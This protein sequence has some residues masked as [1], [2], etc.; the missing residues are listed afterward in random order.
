MYERYFNLRELPFNVTPDPR[1]FYTNP[2]SREALATLCYGIEYRKG[3]ILVTGEAGTGKTTLLKLFMQNAA[4]QV[5]AALILDP[6]LSFVELLHCA[7]DGFGLAQMGENRF[8][9]IERFT[10]YLLEQRNYHHRVALLLDEAQELAD[11]LLEELRLL[12]DLEHGGDKLLQL[13]LIGQPELESRLDQEKFRQL[14]QRI[15]LRSHV[16]PL[17]AE[18]IGPYVGFRLRAAGYSG[19]SIFRAAALQRIGYFSKGIPRLINVI[20]DNALLIACA[21]TQHAI[22]TEIIDEIAEDLRLGGHGAAPLPS[23]P[24]TPVGKSVVEAANSGKT[25]E[26][27]NGSSAS[28]ELQSGVWSRCVKAFM[29]LDRLAGPRV[30]RFFQRW[31]L[32]ISA[33]TVTAIVVSLGG[34]Y[35]TQ[36]DSQPLHSSAIGKQQSQPARTY[37]NLIEGRLWE[38]SFKEHTQPAAIYE[39]PEQRDTPASLE[40]KP[41][42]GDRS[43]SAK[44]P[45][46]ARRF[47]GGQ[48]LALVEPQKTEAGRAQSSVPGYTVVEN[49]YVRDKPT[50]KAEV[51]ATL[52]PGTRIQVVGRFGDYFEV[53]SSDHEAIRGYV[54]KEDAFFRPAP[55]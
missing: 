38:S 16:A 25:D 3:V 48:H 44:A 8:G 5:R 49:S 18:E 23:P 24:G 46:V 17:E 4:P 31:W 42:G 32:E 41:S 9:L 34:I 27:G 15:T 54:H 33:A 43:Q 1:F 22:G 21:T 53:R 13:V 26:I 50:S 52:R 19:K 14:R 55:P 6:H 40:K 30:Q 20:C 12:S 35:L 47:D 29:M 51:I 11:P 10:Q 7:L 28:A 36:P 45:Q 39:E 37:R 2:S